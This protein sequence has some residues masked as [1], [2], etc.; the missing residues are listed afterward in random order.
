MSEG[1]DKTFN[2]I[3]LIE[4]EHIHKWFENVHALND[5]SLKVYPG[6]V[7]VL[8]GDNGAGKSTLVNILAGVIQPTEGKIKCMG[9]EVKIRSVEDSRKLGIEAVYQE[10]ALLNTFTV[11]QNIFINRE[12]V[13]GASL[14]KILDFKKMNQEAEKLT[15]AL[16]LKIPNMNQEVRFCSG[17]ER[18]GVAIA[19]AL[20]FK[21]K[22]V[23]LDEPTTALSVEGVDALLSFVKALK[24]EGIACIIV[25]HRIDQIF[26]IADR[27]VF[28]LRGKKVREIC[29]KDTN[30]NEVED[31][32]RKSPIKNL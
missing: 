19:R 32:L 20:Y 4:I 2:M 15:K 11:T 27:F 9:K 6:E 25:T 14:F 3:P 7:L 21:S 18:Q 26:P 23:I 12:I 22:L 1:I 13:K 8:V 30:L 24:S 16:K 5:V 29:K 10:Q 17:G 31:F 28:L